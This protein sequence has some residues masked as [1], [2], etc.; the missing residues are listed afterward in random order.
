MTPATRTEWLCGAALAAIIAGT[1]AMAGPA[2]DQWLSQ[3]QAADLAAAQ[4]RQ[5]QAEDRALARLQRRLQVDC[6]NGVAVVTDTQPRRIVC[7]LR[8]PRGR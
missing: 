8:Q 6:G 2:L 4:Q 5:A 7:G 3:S 1:L